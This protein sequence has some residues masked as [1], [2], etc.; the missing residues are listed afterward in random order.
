[1]VVN[2]IKMTYSIETVMC[3]GNILTAGTTGMGGGGVTP[4]KK[5]Q[6]GAQLAQRRPRNAGMR[7]VL[8]IKEFSEKL[9][10]KQFEKVFL[11][12]N[13]L[14]L[15]FGKFF[16]TFRFRKKTV[17]NPPLPFPLPPEKCLL[18]R[19]IFFRETPQ[20]GGLKF[21]NLH[22]PPNQIPLGTALC[23]KEYRKL[24]M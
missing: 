9:R 5:S 3:T 1:M 7:N 8:N 10:S 17:D 12:P 15:V 11:S 16:G 23:V 20:G 2:A 22:P 21:L 14:K 13:Y 4:P 24:K 6:K 19:K 18:S